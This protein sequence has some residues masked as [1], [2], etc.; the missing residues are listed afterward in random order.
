V[1]EW[2]V[3]SV[4]QLLIH[5]GLDKYIPEFTV[6]QVN[7]S[8]FLD[9]DGNKLKAMGIYNHSDR[10]IIKKKVKTIKSRIEKERKTL[11]KESRARSML[12]VMSIQ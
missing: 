5:I 1:L 10:S 2:S 7:G 4:C 9:L 11:E 6:N 12:K 3:D 8:K